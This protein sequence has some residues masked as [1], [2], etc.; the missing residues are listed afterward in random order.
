MSKEEKA[1]RRTLEKEARQADQE[2]WTNLRALEKEEKAKLRAVEKEA[3]DLPAVSKEEKAKLRAVEKEARQ[4][5]QE[6]WTN[7]RALE[8]EEKA[9]LR[10]VEKEARQALRDF[11]WSEKAK[12]CTPRRII[13]QADAQDM[14]SK[15]KATLAE[16]DMMQK[17]ID[18][19]ASSRFDELRDHARI[20]R[21]YGTKWDKARVC[22]LDMEGNKNAQPY[23]ISVAAEGLR[24]SWLMN[25]CSA[26]ALAT[27]DDIEVIALSRSRSRCLFRSLFFSRR[28]RFRARWLSS[29][30]ARARARAF[31]RA[32]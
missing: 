26:G 30:L 16:T 2:W 9:K 22:F 8:K 18:S 21:N 19:I 24:R 20:V 23:S 6:W 28:A 13:S 5:D 12:L 31:A 10:A 27:V 7:L 1:K 14:A 17:C 32:C 25:P 11:E 3:D 29:S 4:A 15:V